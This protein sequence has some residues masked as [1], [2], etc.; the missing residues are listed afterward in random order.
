V[1]EELAKYLGMRPCPDCEGTRLNRA[2]RFVFV[3]ER[4]LP[5]TAH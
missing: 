4:T 2:A 3:A 5:E 1:R